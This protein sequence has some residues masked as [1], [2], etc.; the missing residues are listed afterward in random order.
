MARSGSAGGGTQPAQANIIGVVIL[1]LFLGAFFIYNSV[2]NLSNAGSYLDFIRQSTGPHGA[3]VKGNLWPPFAH[4]LVTTVNQHSQAFGWA[5]LII[6]L[7][8]GV[9]FLFGFLT[10]LAALLA[11]AFNLFFLLAMLHDTTAPVVIYAF[12]ANLALIMMELVVLIGAAGRTLGLDAL[13]AQRTRIRL[14]W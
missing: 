5:I 10:R 11:M 3:F 9:L 8:I 13:L 14:F 12:T 2:V 4:F 1:R 6:G 7:L